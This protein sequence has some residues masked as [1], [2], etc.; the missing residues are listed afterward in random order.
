[1]KIIRKTFFKNDFQALIDTIIEDA[2]LSSVAFA[3]SP[4]CWI[5][6]WW[7]WFWWELWWLLS[8][9]TKLGRRTR[10]S[11]WSFGGIFP[12]ASLPSLVSPLSSLATLGGW[13][14]LGLQFGIF[15]H[16]NFQVDCDG[17]HLHPCH[18]RWSGH[19]V[20]HLFVTY[21]ICNYVI[22]FPKLICIS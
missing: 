17:R 19:F 15:C 11:L 9:Y 6:W 14:A 5:R 4:V 3:T 8:R 22:I 16:F 13:F 10:S 18:A 1:M 21:K 12:F 2:N 20:F 7:Q